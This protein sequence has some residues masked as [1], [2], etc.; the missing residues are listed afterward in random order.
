[1]LIVEIL[2]KILTET[3]NERI[4]HELANKSLLVT[5]SF[6][7]EHRALT[8]ASLKTIMSW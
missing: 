3:P 6:N 7:Y 1:M 2:A 4:D 5:M 8:E